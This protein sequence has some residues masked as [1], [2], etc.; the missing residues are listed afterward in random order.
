MN[1]YRAVIRC[2]TLRRELGFVPRQLVLWVENK[3][4]DNVVSTSRE[5]PEH[6]SELLNPPQ[7]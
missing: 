5:G 7:N 4:Q 3:L 1:V 6:S 2:Q